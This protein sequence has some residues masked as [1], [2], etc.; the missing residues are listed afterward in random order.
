MTLKIV[1]ASLFVLAVTLVFCLLQLLPAPFRIQWKDTLSRQYAATLH[2]LADDLQESCPAISHQYHHDIHGDELWL[3]KESVHQQLWMSNALEI[4]VFRAVTLS[5]M[6]RIENIL[7]PNTL[8]NSLIYP[9]NRWRTEHQKQKEHSLPYTK[10][11]RS[12]NP[13]QNTRT[14]PPQHINFNSVN[15]GSDTNNNPNPSTPLETSLN[16]NPLSNPS[17][18]DRFSSPDIKSAPRPVYPSSQGQDQLYPLYK[19]NNASS[20]PSTRIDSSNPNSTLFTSPKPQRNPPLNLL[21]LLLVPLE[22]HSHPYPD[23]LSRS[24]ISHPPLDSASATRMRITSREKEIRGSL[25]GMVIAV[26][27][28]VMWL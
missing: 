26:V 2:F 12:E 10:V 7:T 21:S 19:S 23:R 27:V 14:N 1:G 15:S 18:A 3:T 20:I 24:S 11:P 13:S 8:L 17:T 25:L 9:Y 16:S 22:Q 4:N 28:G 5:S 6:W